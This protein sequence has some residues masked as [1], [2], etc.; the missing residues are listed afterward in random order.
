[1]LKE[2]KGFLQ[3]GNVVDLA[4]AVIIGGAFGAIVTSLVNDIVMPL[5][6]VLLGGLDFSSLAIQV[7][8]ATIA[9]GHFIQAIV[10]FVIIGFVLFLVMRSYNKMKVGEK[11]A[12]EAAPPAPSGEE[13]LL[14]EIR[15]LIKERT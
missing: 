3:Q 2:F 10:N 1:M 14:G 6:G 7:G 9:Y 15:D 12:E 8:A 4:V 5:V 13:V 11:E